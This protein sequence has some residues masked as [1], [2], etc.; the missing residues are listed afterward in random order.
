[1]KL[2]KKLTASIPSASSSSR[3]KESLV[4]TRSRRMSSLRD[5]IVDANLAT[6]NLQIRKINS[7]SQQVTYEREELYS[8]HMTASFFFFSLHSSIPFLHSPLLFCF[9]L[10]VQLVLFSENCIMLIE[11]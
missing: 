11:R 5:G 9:F 2:E 4:V 1:M 6:V 10:L 8:A 3:R 7:D